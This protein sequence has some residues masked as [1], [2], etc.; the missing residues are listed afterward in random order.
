YDGRDTLY[1]GT[2]PNGL[3]YRV[4]RQTG[5]LFV[6]YDAAESEVSALVLDDQGN[7]YAGTS[8]AVEG[9]I[10]RAAD[11]AGTGPIGRPES[12]PGGVPIPAQP[13]ADPTPPELPDPNPSEPDPIPTT[14]PSAHGAARMGGWP[15]STGFSPN[16]ITTGPAMPPQWQSTAW[17]ALR[18]HAP[19]GQPATWLP[20]ANP[21]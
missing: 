3:V 16:P 13:P 20:I 17:P 18:V 14:Q 12:E 2:D 11:T 6:L 9:G 19:H 8:E 1:I 7:V 10:A 21:L 5:E 15:V 4:N